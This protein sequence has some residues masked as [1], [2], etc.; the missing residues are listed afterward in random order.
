MSTILTYRPLPDAT[1][2]VLAPE[3]P[4]QRGS[5]ARIR[6]EHYRT[7]MTVQE[8]LDACGIIGDIYHD[9]SRAFIAV[10]DYPYADVV[11]RME[12]GQ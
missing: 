2:T 1:I 11:A 9:I 8:Y 10:S 7:G 5:Q 12:Q 4:K 6:F 3:N